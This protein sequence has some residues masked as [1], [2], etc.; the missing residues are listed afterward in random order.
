MQKKM[1]IIFFGICFLAALLAETYCIQ[2]LEGDLFS[3]VGIGV[4]VLITAYLLMDSIRSYIKQSRETI[5]SYV[6]CMLKE[7]KERWDTRYTELSNIQKATYAV[8][9]KNTSL[10]SEQMG[11]LLSRLVDMEE[12]S[13]KEWQRMTELQMRSMEGQKNALNMQLHYDKENT[14]QIIQVLKEEKSETDFQEKLVNI[15]ELLES[16]YKFLKTQID[17]LDEEKQTT[18]IS[19]NLYKDTVMN[20]EESGKVSNEPEIQPYEFDETDQTDQSDHSP[21]NTELLTAEEVPQIEEEVLPFNKEDIKTS[22]ETEVLP[23]DAE[24]VLTNET[25]VASNNI[26]VIPIYDDPNKSLSADE[27][28]A[29]FASVGEINYKSRKSSSLYLLRSALFL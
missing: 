27:I 3:T 17:R 1:N 13:A 8:T 2:I 7:E 28:A 4:V 23:S 9:K 15:L 11:E 6:D 19:E 22:D 5:T 20:S 26:N 14:G 16:N 10:L 21:T 29:L 18:G 25:T 24:D 12:S